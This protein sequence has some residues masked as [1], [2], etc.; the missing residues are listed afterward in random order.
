MGVTVVVDL[1]CYGHP[2]HEGAS[3]DSVG[4]LIERFKPDRLYGFDPHPG[5]V[6]SA[7]YE[8][9]TAVLLERKA[10]WVRDGEISYHANGLASEILQ[11]DETVSCFDLSPWLRSI[12]EQVI[13]KMD[14]EGAEYELLWHI[15]RTGNAGTIKRLLV[16]WHEPPVGPGDWEYQRGYITDSVP[17]PVE[18]WE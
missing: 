2:D 14:V 4:Q 8:G 17:F 9:T 6:T 11:G 18:A 15:I 10:A 12:G 1:G 3:Q 7:I 5:Q 13:L 16:E